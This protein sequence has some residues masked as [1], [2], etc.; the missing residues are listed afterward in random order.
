[1]RIL[2]SAAT[3]LF[4][5]SLFAQHQLPPVAVT[6][7][8]APPLPLRHITL[9]SSLAAQ[10][11]DLANTL[12]E[13]PGLS[14]RSQGNHAAE[15][16]LRG[17]AWERVATD[18][19]GLALH[20]GC[21][22]RMDPPLSLFS[23]VSVSR[24]DVDLGPSSVIHGPGGLAGRIRL[25]S[26]LEWNPEAPAPASTILLGSAASNGKARAASVSA[27]NESRNAA[28]TGFYQLSR[29]D[30]TFAADGTRVPAQRDK[31]EIGADLALLHSNLRSS[32]GLRWIDESDVDYPALPMDTRSSETLLIT[33]ALSWQPEAAHLDALDLRLGVSRVDH[34]MDN[35]DKPNRGLMIASTPTRSDTTNGR[36]LSTWSFEPA[37]LRLGTDASRLER[38]AVRTRTMPATGKTFRDPIWPD[39][40]QDQAGLFAEVEAP[41]NEGL[42]LRSGLRFDQVASQADDADARIVPGPAI[43]PT[44][45]RNSWETY[46]G[47]EQPDDSRDD[48]LV[49]GNIVL[50]SPLTPQWT[51]QIGLSRVAALPNLTQLYRAF[52]PE[53]G[54]YNIGNPSLDP[55]VK[56]QIELRLDGRAGPH[57]LGFALH[58]SRVDDFALPVTLARLDIDGDG[59]A[60]RLRG[61]RNVDAEFWGAESSALL[62]L[63]PE[64]TL[65]LRAAWLRGR[66][67]DSGDDLP[68]IP[69]LETAAALRWERESA[70]DPWMEFGL[71][72]A[73]KQTQIDRDF[74]EDETP[75]FAVFHL[76]CGFSPRPGLRLEAGV[77]NL[78]D[79]QYHEH[80]TREAVLPVGD[81]AL[82]DE[83]P[84][85]GRSFALSV[86]VQW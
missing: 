44:T 63:A 42:R 85:P 13:V 60:D 30:D 1:M 15:P 84:A 48:S 11:G 14:L 55:E 75:S 73:H 23:A 59:K 41:L 72:H 9:P 38:D 20:G 64:W 46:G 31:S 43:G 4:C 58:A 10:Q 39:L 8:S 61:T 32:L 57:A 67:A 27:R 54:G 28:A 83:I 77:E 65:P 69:P 76:R 56:H 5:G 62:R 49:S 16:V 81:L 50:E 40:T 37:I 33:P 36:L 6:G 47:A 21:P 74:G 24:V 71:R 19:N 53:P 34:L 68:E 66:N 12:R 7:E 51:S 18:F 45:I 80:L 35:R 29:Q 52:S 82:G 3:A 25:D 86:Q 22:S 17:M 70:S 78:F 2:S 26:S 79:R